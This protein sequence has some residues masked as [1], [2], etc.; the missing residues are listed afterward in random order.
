MLST[1][2]TLLARGR[3]ENKFFFKIEVCSK[4]F[5][6]DY[7]SKTFLMEASIAARLRVF[8]ASYEFSIELPATGSSISLPWKIFS[9]G[10]ASLLSG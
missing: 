1:F 4:Y 5:V 6:K 9:F 3:E 10:I 8:G 7:S 2:S